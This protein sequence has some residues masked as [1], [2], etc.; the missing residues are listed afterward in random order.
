MKN[1]TVTIGPNGEVKV[2]ANGFKGK[3]CD[4]A[5]KAI[6][7]ALGATASETKK[8]EYNMPDMEARHA[9]SH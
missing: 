6:R 9:T 5:T 8:A 2:E 3:G 1:I 4:A 7:E